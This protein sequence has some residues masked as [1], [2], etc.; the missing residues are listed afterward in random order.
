MVDDGSKDRSADIIKYYE[1][2]YKGII[3]GSIK[4]SRTI[5]QEINARS[6]NRDI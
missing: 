4:K 3:R 1:K 5:T 2:K 6:C